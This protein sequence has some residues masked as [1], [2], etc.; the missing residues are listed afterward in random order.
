M[1]GLER[2]EQVVVGARDEARVDERGVDALLGQEPCHAAAL[3]EE[4]A[5]GH[6]G[7]AAAAVCHVI[8]VDVAVV[9]GVLLI[10][11]VHLALG[12]TDGHAVL[13]LMD[14]P[15]LHGDHLLHRG[16]CEVDEVGDV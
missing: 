5:E 8:A 10:A 15:V 1:V 14:G 4:V 13:V 11:V 16:G 6:E 7:H 2:A 3:V 9:G 12:H